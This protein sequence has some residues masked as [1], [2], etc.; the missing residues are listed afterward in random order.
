MAEGKCGAC[1]G[2]G[3]F[4]IYSDGEKKGWGKDKEVVTCK[5]CGGTG[6]KR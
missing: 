1:G 3:T 4:I 5:D 6:R 2:E